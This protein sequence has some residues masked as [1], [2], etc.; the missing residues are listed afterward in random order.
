MRARR[1]RAAI[2][3]LGLP[4]S[5]AGRPSGTHDSRNSRKRRVARRGTAGRGSGWTCGRARSNMGVVPPAQYQ[6]GQVL[7]GTVYRVMRHLATGG[8]GSVYDVEDTTVEKRYVVKT[9]HPN[10]VSRED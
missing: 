8:M 7:P 3:L 9:L 4:A 5:H 6:P 2:G 10:L 1:T